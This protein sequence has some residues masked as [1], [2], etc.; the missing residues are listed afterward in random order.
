M[1][2]ADVY[3]KR[4]NGNADVRFC[5]IIAKEW[6][7][8]KGVPNSW[9]GIGN[10]AYSETNKDGLYSCGIRRSALKSF[11]KEMED[12]SLTIESEIRPL[13]M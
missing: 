1:K 11:V 3:I 10:E 8:K 12:A 7:K 2:D 9:E 6:A 5:S 4:E 13:D